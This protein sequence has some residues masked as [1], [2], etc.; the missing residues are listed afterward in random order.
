MAGP[1]HRRNVPPS[2]RDE[3]LREAGYMC[4]IPSCRHILTLELHH[5]VWVKAGGGNDATNLLALC[6]NHHALHTQG[7]IPDSAIRHWKGMLHALNHSFSKESMDLL[8]FLANPS[9]KD[10]YYSGDGVLRFAGLIA[11]GLA[12][13]GSGAIVHMTGGGLGGPKS[14]HHVVLSEKGTALVDAW[15]RGDEESY[16]AVLRGGTG[17]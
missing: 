4:A 1:P 16:S 2:V 10:I 6:A 12:Q 13:L 17:Q 9:S 5:I 15:I 8:L 7:H 14:S 3:V 11:A